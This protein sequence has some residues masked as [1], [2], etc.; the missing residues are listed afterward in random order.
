MKLLLTIE[1]NGKNFSG[2]QI[3]PRKR[4][5]QQEIENSLESLFGLKIKIHGSG[6]TDS[7]VHAMGQTA[8]FEIPKMSL[9]KFITNSKLEKS[10]LIMAINANLPEDIKILKIREVS[11]SFHARYDVKEKIYLYKMQINANRPSPLLTN[12][13]GTYKKS[14]DIQKMRGGAKFLIGEHNFK[15]FSNVKT[16]VQDFNRKIN[17][18]K[19]N[20]KNDMVTFEISG[21]GFLYNMVRIIVG[22]LVDVGIYKINPQDIKIILDAEDRTKAGKTVQPEGLYLKKVRY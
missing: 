13:V 16:E 21:N 10:K 3:Q 18:I 19:I 5:V 22:T 4:S 8:H 20:K 12:L 1:Y 15:S 14:L 7:G 17:Y 2:W 11:N 9:K 6:R